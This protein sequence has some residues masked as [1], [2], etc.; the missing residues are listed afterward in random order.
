M[1]P[2]SS[3]WGR[4]DSSSKFGIVPGVF[5]VSTP[6]HGGVMMPVE[7]ARHYGIEDFADI[8]QTKH[9]PWACFEEDCNIA[10]AAMALFLR[11]KLPLDDEKLKNVIISISSWNHSYWKTLNFAEFGDAGRRV[12]RLVSELEDTLRNVNEAREQR[13]KENAMRQNKDPS[14]IV[15]AVS[16]DSLI[17]L[18]RYIGVPNAEAKDLIRKFEFIQGDLL[19]LFDGHKN[20]LV[21]TADNNQHIVR[22]YEVRSPNLLSACEL[23]AK[24]IN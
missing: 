22:N 6:S 4:I 1:R 24:V 14:L 10:V 19:S 17:D 23:V 18:A 20:V 16:F 15:A 13:E 21:W 7:I 3:P 8:H 12:L 9:V 5:I 11:D 2:S